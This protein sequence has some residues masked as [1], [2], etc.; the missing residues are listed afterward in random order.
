MELVYC[1]QRGDSFDCSTGPLCNSSY[2]FKSY[3]KNIIIFKHNWL[4]ILLLACLV[5]D[6][7][8]NPNI[9]QLLENRTSVLE[10]F[11]KNKWT[12]SVSPIK[13]LCNR[14]HLSEMAAVL[15]SIQHATKTTTRTRTKWSVRFRN[16]WWEQKLLS[17]FLSMFAV[18]LV[19]TH[20]IKKGGAHNCQS[21]GLRN[22]TLRR[23]SPFKRKGNESLSNWFLRTHL[24]FPEFHRRRWRWQQRWCWWWMFPLICFCFVPTVLTS[25]FLTTTTTTTAT[26]TTITNNNNRRQQRER[27]RSDL[28]Y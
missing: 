25:P 23:T 17:N 3:C 19:T 12:R 11:S 7:K 24:L 2:R 6:E 20:T 5:F 1:S 9:S 21:Q 4:F 22:W 14:V 10:I 18:S 13:E 16:D 26:A 15:G 27:P 8:I 28:H